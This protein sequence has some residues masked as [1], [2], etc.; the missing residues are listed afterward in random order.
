MKY[1]IFLLGLMIYSNNGY[2]QPHIITNIHTL[3]EADCGIIENIF[4]N[5]IRE[6]NGLKVTVFIK[7][8]GSVEHRTFLMRWFKIFPF[9]YKKILE[10]L[11]L[12]GKD[13]EY[14][15]VQTDA[16]MVLRVSSTINSIGY[17]DDAKY[18]QD[19]KSIKIILHHY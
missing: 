10:T 17:I 4:E 14:I 13:V 19:K 18:V 15:E 3:N 9:R 16:E 7:P 6:V 8:M 5:K 11:S 12:S 1:Y 2:S